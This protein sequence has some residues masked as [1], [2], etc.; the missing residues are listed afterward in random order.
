MKDIAYD[1]RAEMDHTEIGSV[2]LPA[3]SCEYGSESSCF[4]K[5]EGFL[6]YCSSYLLAS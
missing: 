4:I 6:D 2:W 5:G 1:E 3:G